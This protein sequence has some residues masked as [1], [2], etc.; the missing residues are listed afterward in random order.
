MS[1][2]IDRLKQRKVTKRSAKVSL[3]GRVLY[4]VD[5]ADAI[6][7][8][9]QGEDLSPQH[10]LDYRDNIST[11]EMTPA[12]VCYYHDETLGEFPYVGY[13]AGGEFPFTR[14]SVKEG[15]FAASSER[16]PVRGVGHSSLSL[17]GPLPYGIIVVRD[18]TTVCSI[19]VEEPDS[20][21]FTV[22]V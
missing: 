6:Q 16:V 15:G 12:Y 14:N 7:R 5:D 2:L 9:L 17:L 18:P 19:V 22:L 11:D 4:L 3:E 1:D 8:Q 10:G 13:S 21:P 20:I